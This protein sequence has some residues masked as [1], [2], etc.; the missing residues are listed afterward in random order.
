[1]QKDEY[2]ALQLVTKSEPELRTK[3]IG[4]SATPLVAYMIQVIPTNSSDFAPSKCQALVELMDT[5]PPQHIR[6]CTLQS[7]LH[8][9]DMSSAISNRAELWLLIF[10]LTTS[11]AGLWT[12][13]NTAKECDVA[14]SRCIKTVCLGFTWHFMP[15]DI[16]YNDEQLKRAIFCLYYGKPHGQTNGQ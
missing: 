4:H 5:P 6:Y 13:H 3:T 2:K 12:T 11:N 16:T 14:A 1:M 10:V 8:A 7:S 15:L 9:K